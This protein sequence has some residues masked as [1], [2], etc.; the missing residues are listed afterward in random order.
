MYYRFFLLIVLLTRV[1]CGFA[2][3]EQENKTEEICL[4]EV[5]LQGLLLIGCEEELVSNREELTQIKGIQTKSV[6]VPG[7]ICEL[8]NAIWDEVEG[9]ALDSSAVERIKQIL[10]QYYIRKQYPFVLFRI[11]S[12]RIEEGVVQIIVEPSRVGTVQVDGNR[13][14]S[15]EKIQRLFKIQPDDWIDQGDVLK[16]LHFLNKNTFRQTDLVYTPGEAPNTTDLNLIVQEKDS[17]RLYSGVDNTGVLSTGRQ[18]FFAGVTTGN[19]F[20][21]G[22]L[23]S[24]QY[25]ASFDFKDLQAATVQYLAFLESQTTLNVYGGYS[26]VKA[27][28]PFPNMRNHGQSYQGSVR[29]SGSLR[30]TPEITQEYEVGFDFRAT[31]NTV[32]FV[33]EFPIVS[34]LVNLTQLEAGYSIQKQ[35]RSYSVF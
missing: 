33:E 17:W 20:W 23:F 35:N 1:V 28:L 10:N 11:P 9:R 30:P 19:A 15:K 34:K 22:D 16:G 5:A 32:E 24:A 18:R 27:D 3:E 26:S 12:Q 25:T 6:F 14:D 8:Q 13:W 7:S 2:N 31:N 29:Y 21:R 4:K